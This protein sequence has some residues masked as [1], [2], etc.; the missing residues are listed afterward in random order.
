MMRNFASALR[1][2]AIQSRRVS[3]RF[4]SFAAAEKQSGSPD[5]ELG[6]LGRAVAAAVAVGASGLGLWLLPSTSPFPDSSRSFADSDLV[7]NEPLFRNEAEMKK[8]P[9]F[10]FAGVPSLQ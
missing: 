6:P 7:Q 10:L 8:K 1:G 9:K 3:A 4:G 2:S 5:H